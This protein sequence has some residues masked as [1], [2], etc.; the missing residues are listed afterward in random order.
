[1]TSEMHRTTYPLT[2]GRIA[3]LLD[4]SLRNAEVLHGIPSMSYGIVE[5]GDSHHITADYSFEVY[6]TTTGFGFAITNCLIHEMTSTLR[7]RGWSG[8][9]QDD[10]LL[11]QILATITRHWEDRSEESILHL[12]RR[13]APSYA[14][15]HL[16]DSVW[17]A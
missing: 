7:D 11:V 8:V 15:G 4:S 2:N 5:L 10:P 3:D 6:V 12:I 13:A 14:P 17:D 9:L 16:E 1:M